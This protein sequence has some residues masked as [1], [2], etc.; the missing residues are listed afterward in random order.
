MKSIKAFLATLSIGAL[1]ASASSTPVLAQA[2]KIIWESCP[3]SVSRTGAQC[4]RIDVPRDYDNPDGE[5]ISVGFVQFKATKEA[6]D[7]IFVNPGG[8]SGDVYEWLGNTKDYDFPAEF[9][10]NY[11]IIGVQPRGLPG[12]TPLECADHIDPSNPLDSYFRNGGQLRD[13]CE[14]GNPGLVAEV[15]TENT[16][17]DWEEVRKALS[18]DRISIYG[19]SYGTILGSTYATLFPTQTNR[20]VLD[21][22]IDSEL[23]W[24]EIMAKQNPGYRQGLHDF[25]DW[26]AK[27]HDTLQLG[28]TAYIVY[29]RWAEQVRRESGVWPPV[30]PP[31]ATAS[32]V[33]VQGSGQ[34]GV[35]AMN[36]IEP[37]RAQSENLSSQLTTGSSVMESMLYSFTYLNVPNPSHWKT[38]A[39]SISNPQIIVDYYAKYSDP[40]EQEVRDM[41]SSMHMQEIIM[42]NE[43]QTPPNRSQ[44]LPALWNYTFTKDI[45][46]MGSASFVSGMACE[47]ASPIAKVPTSNGSKLKVRPLQLQATGD[48]QT[49]YGNFSNMQRNMNSH[50]ITIKGPGHGQFGTGNKK[51]DKVVLEYFAGS[52]PTVTDLPGYFG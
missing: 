17:R 10:E 7:T 6:K 38:L 45:F 12:S 34:T 26:A 50:L 51:V 52:T 31:K 5:Q 22:G 13:A 3:T 37:Q 4:G 29:Q 46:S 33:P 21:S 43:A 42:C 15:T 44:F 9:F 2:A 24:S 48:P 27:N 36:A 8:P 32:D 19:L 14:K 39:N 20:V 1:I 23:M 40:T 30:E 25:F 16:A 11:T 28:E 41:Q 35:D 47:G 18:K 49:P